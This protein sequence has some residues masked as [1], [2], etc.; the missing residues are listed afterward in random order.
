MVCICT[1]FQPSESRAALPILSSVLRHQVRLSASRPPSS[2]GATQRISL[3]QVAVGLSKNACPSAGVAYAL[4]YHRRLFSAPDESGATRAGN[5]DPV[6]WTRKERSPRMHTP[7]RTSR[8]FFR[9]QSLCREYLIEPQKHRVNSYIQSGCNIVQLL[10]KSLIISTGCIKLH[11]P[12]LDED[13]L[14]GL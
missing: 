9:S 7:L 8:T 10:R 5:R 2:R 11:S 4:K 3:G 14:Y 13:A 12:R 1:G 6:R